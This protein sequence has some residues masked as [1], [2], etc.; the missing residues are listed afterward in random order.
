MFPLQVRTQHWNGVSAKRRAAF[1][2]TSVF[3]GRIAECVSGPR[4][5][6]PVGGWADASIPTDSIGWHC[7]KIMNSHSVCNALGITNGVGFIRVFVKFAFH[8]RLN[9]SFYYVSHDMGIL[10]DL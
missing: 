5:V 2:G 10:K 4:W 6:P 9:G 3:S 8:L 1:T 7:K